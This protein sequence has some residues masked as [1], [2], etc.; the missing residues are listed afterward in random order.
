M[1]TAGTATKNT[2]S[3]SVSCP[4]RN[5]EN[6]GRKT[7]M[8]KEPRLIK[9]SIKRGGKTYKASYYIL[10]GIITVVSAWGHKSTQ[11]GDL[12]PETLARLL[13][14]ELIETEE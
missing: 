7:P 9:F 10:Q 2:P 13:L 8:A 6:S 11:V 3:L 4:E 12:P 1:F 5:L 14:R